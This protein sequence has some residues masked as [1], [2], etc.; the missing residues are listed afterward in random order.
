MITWG[1][2]LLSSLNYVN[3][4][5]V[6][7][8]FSKKNILCALAVFYGMAVWCTHLYLHIMKVYCYNNDDN[9]DNKNNTL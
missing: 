8:K 2:K 1:K 3:Y 7:R 6:Q 9:D 5:D 4:T